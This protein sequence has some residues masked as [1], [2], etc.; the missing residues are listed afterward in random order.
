MDAL[1]AWARQQ[2]LGGVGFYAASQFIH[3]DTGPDR[4]KSNSMPS[5]GA[6]RVTNISPRRRLS[7]VSA[8]CTRNE[9][10]WPPAVVMLSSSTASSAGIPEALFDSGFSGWPRWSVT[11]DGDRFLVNRPIE[12]S[13]AGA[14][15]LIQNWTSALE[16]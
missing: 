1:H 16:R 2:R 11:P 8:T 15:T 6:M 10:A 9:W 4:P 13:A 5:S 3:M 7:G 14:L 12:R